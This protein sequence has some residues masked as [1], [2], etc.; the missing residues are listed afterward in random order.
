[1]L[2]RRVL[3]RPPRCLAALSSSLERPTASIRAVRIPSHSS[4]SRGHWSAE[5]SAAVPPPS[6]SPPP[7]PPPLP[8]RLSHRSSVARVPPRRCSCCSLP[9]CRLSLPRLT[10]RTPPLPPARPVPPPVFPSSSA[11]PPWMSVWRI[12]SSMRPI[13]S[14]IPASPFTVITLALVSARR[15]ARLD[16]TFW[17]RPWAW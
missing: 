10:R 12:R 11:C 3:P 6:P 16:Q 14:H 17:I 9:P 4:F 13:S 15:L 1:M 5:P 7:P 2:P 8:A